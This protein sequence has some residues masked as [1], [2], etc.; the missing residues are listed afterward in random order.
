MFTL[1]MLC[2]SI[3]VTL[4]HLCIITGLQKQKKKE[5]SL[6]RGELS[7]TKAVHRQY[8]I[9]SKCPQESVFGSCVPIG[10]IHPRAIR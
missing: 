8:N 10:I 5:R 1:Q 2:G 4:A 6:K 9:K 3:G 7:M